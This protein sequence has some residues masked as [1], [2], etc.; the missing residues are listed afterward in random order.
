M[1]P[2]ILLFFLGI[3]FANAIF[4]YPD[5]PYQEHL[6]E[7]KNT[8]ANYGYLLEHGDDALLARIHLIRN[9]R[10]SIDIQTFI[11]KPDETGL[12]LFYEL[13]QA[14]LRG[15]KV[16]ILID[17]LSI[18]AIHDKV[19]YLAQ[20]SENI[21][22]KQYNPVADSINIGLV[23]TAATIAT[24]FGKYNHR[25]HNK[26]VVVDDQYGIT[27]GRNYQNDYFDRGANRTFLDRDILVIGSVAGDMSKSF[28][29]YWT[30]DLAVFSKD[31]KDV[32]KTIETD[33]IEIPDIAH[34]Y[35]AP[36]MFSE[37]SKCAATAAC[38]NER[39]SSK[40]TKL[41]QIEFVADHPGKHE[42]GDDLAETT[43]SLLELLSNT[44]DKIV[45]QTPYLVVHK[46]KVFN[47]LR[48]E[49]PEM[50]II[51]S[52]NSL[53][54]ADH[55]YAYAFSYKNK[56]HYVKKFEWQIHE[57]KPEPLDFSQMIYPVP[58]I[59]RTKNHYACIHAKTYLFDNEVVWL[60]SFNLDPR[61][62]RLNTEAG[63]IIRDPEF[64]E[65]VESNIELKITARNAWSTGPRKTIPVIGF[66][67]SIIEDTFALIPFANLW[68]F[69]YSTSYELREGGVE[70]PI[71]AEDFHKNYKSVGQ[72]PGTKVTPKAVKTRLTK[73][74]LGP[75]QPI[76]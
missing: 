70:M 19:A 42:D 4:A 11:W 57:M 28:Q 2:K 36:A 48:K 31:M 24:Q 54:A 12:F 32:R 27:G 44:H 47:D 56:K 50:E 64:Y 45:F 15:V 18:R 51:V 13:W 55:F 22:I 46:K 7:V 35:Q 72:F 73:A 38:V 61:S 6:D 16:R 71:S 21:E 10:E 67:N 65:L 33:S 59:E 60:G 58:Q 34:G 62:A 49:N 3:F 26:V 74:F 76:I 63:V 37:L 39:I 30:N 9:A 20:L 69:T 66:F 25:M 75:A 5:N 68:P 17:D 43:E 14:A 29:E 53:G 8:Q 23:K 52:T 40:G 1:L 41:D